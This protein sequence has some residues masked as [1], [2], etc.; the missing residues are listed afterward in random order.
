MHR[1][2]QTS[3]CL[4]GAG[5]LFPRPFIRLQPPLLRAGCLIVDRLL[6]LRYRC[7]QD[8][9][10]LGGAGSLGLDRSS[11][12]IHCRLQQASLC[13]NSPSALRIDHSGITVDT[14]PIGVDQGAHGLVSRVVLF[15]GGAHSLVIRLVRLESKVVI[16]PQLLELSF[17]EVDRVLECRAVF[18]C[19]GLSSLDCGSNRLDRLGIAAHCILQTIESLCLLKREHDRQRERS[20]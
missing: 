2:L 15:K 12:A 14:V 6:E 19:G 17:E 9:L 5:R 10:A 18:A 20:G 11:G 3:L 8:S 4:G 13:L 7:V 16:L 1:L